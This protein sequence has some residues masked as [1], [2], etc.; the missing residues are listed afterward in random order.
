M[1]GKVR[2]VQSDDLLRNVYRSVI[3]G[4]RI[5]R[6]RENTWYFW[7]NQQEFCWYVLHEEYK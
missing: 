2:I 5:Q 3:K 1:I 7:G 4:R 6:L